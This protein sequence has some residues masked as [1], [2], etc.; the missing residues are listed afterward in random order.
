[1]RLI[2]LCSLYTAINYPMSRNVIVY[3]L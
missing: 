2:D 1:L 3:Q